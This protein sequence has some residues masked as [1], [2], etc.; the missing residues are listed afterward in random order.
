M[1]EVTKEEFKDIY[2]KYFKPDQ[3]W[4]KG[5]WKKILQKTQH[6]IFC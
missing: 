1:K 4:D 3:G 5:Q 2:L 6:E